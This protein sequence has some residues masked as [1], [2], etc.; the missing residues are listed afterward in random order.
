MRVGDFGD[1][2]EGD[3]LGALDALEAGV[4]LTILEAAGPLPPPM[5]DDAPDPFEGGGS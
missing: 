5:T 2:P 3:D 1:D 4:D